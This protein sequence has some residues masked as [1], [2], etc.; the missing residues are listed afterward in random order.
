LVTYRTS[1]VARKVGLHPNTVR[2]Y[3]TL[4]LIPQPERCPNGYRIFTA[5][6]IRQLILVRTAFSVEVLQSGLRQRAV[7]IVKTSAAGDFDTAL[8]LTT[9]YLEA[10]EKEKMNAEDAIEITGQL[11]S[12]TAAA[13][14]VSLTR[15]ETADLLGITMDTLRNWEMNGLLTVKRRRNGYR[16]YTS[17][18]IRRLKII[19]S[20][21]CANYSLSSILRTLGALTHNPSVS[22]REV[23][24]TPGDSDDIIS[25]CDKLITSLRTAGK[26]AESMLRQLGDMK[27]LFG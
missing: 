9:L 24:N 25:V 5:F 20:L 17:E 12:G 1:E 22:I 16:V 27:I 21:R 8:H 4:G 3:E 6:H 19:R 15:K 26:N 18:D 2:L 14:S 13:E 11:L 7:H 23:I 10:L